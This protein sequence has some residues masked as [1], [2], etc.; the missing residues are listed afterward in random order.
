MEKTPKGDPEVW[1]GAGCGRKACG[2]VGQGSEA[3]STERKEDS[4]SLTHAVTVGGTAGQKMLGA[5]LRVITA[6]LLAD[7]SVTKSR[8]QAP[9]LR[10]WV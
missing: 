4:D 10:V 2:S 5:G 6:M 8:A 7:C 9:A 1:E 3:E